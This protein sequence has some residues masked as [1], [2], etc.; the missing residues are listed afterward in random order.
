M[1]HA[2]SRSWCRTRRRGCTEWWIRRDQ[3]AREGQEVLDR[4]LPAL[5]EAA[6][7]RV[8]GIIGVS[9]PLDAAQDAVNMYTFDEI[10]VSTLPRTVSRWLRLDLPHKL[11]GL[12]LPVTTVTASSQ[13]KAGAA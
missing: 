8:T 9:S 4:A 3:S 10:I 6:G 2:C 13:E 5:S 1:A 7:S 11:E 12:G